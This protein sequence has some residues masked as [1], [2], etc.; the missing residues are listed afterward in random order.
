MRTHDEGKLTSTVVQEVWSNSIGLAYY[1]ST[2]NEDSDEGKCLTSTVVQREVGLILGLDISTVH[3]EDSLR[4]KSC[5]YCFQR[6]WS[7]SIG[8]DSIP[9]HE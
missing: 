4:R 8:L 3:E 5:I 1:H 9:V 6:G 7:N 2:V